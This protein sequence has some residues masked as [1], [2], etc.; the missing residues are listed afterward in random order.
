MANDVYHA[1]DDFIHASPVN[2]QQA[3]SILAKYSEDV[4]RQLINAMYVG[5]SNIHNKKLEEPGENYAGGADHIEQNEFARILYEKN[6]NLK[7]YLQKVVEC[8]KSSN[9]DLKSL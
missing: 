1:M 5:R 2:E 4:Q 3:E 9:F 7:T 6:S 8:S